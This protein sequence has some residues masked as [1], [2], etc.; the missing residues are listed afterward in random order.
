MRWFPPPSDASVLY[1]LVVLLVVL[2]GS[3]GLRASN[4]RRMRTLCEDAELAC[5]CSTV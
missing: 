2:P 5:V 3:F 4:N 1:V